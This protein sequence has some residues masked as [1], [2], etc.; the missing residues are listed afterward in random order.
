[1]S[2]MPGSSPRN[3]QKSG[4]G[5]GGIDGWYARPDTSRQADGSRA[6]GLRVTNALMN[7][8]SVPP[9]AAVQWPATRKARS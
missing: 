5:H 7:G 4:G 1:M 6:F 9:V 3:V 8:R 2:R